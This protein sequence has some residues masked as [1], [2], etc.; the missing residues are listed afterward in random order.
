MIY[1]MGG[2][3]S[4]WGYPLI[5]GGKSQTWMMTEATPMTKRKP[6]CPCV[7]GDALPIPVTRQLCRQQVLEIGKES[8]WQGSWSPNP[9]GKIH[10][11]IPE[12]NGGF[13]NLGTWNC[14]IKRK[15]KCS[16]PCLIRP[17]GTLHIL[18]WEQLLNSRP[19]SSEDSVVRPVP[20][21]SLPQMIIH[22]WK[23]PISPTA[24]RVD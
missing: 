2:S 16:K 4:S 24:T 14:E 5:A 18:L 20:Q 19:R 3:S 11:K 6:P 21:K 8:L 17:E 10:G 12:L 1:H 9:H 15:N 23:G 7:I 13:I 22:V